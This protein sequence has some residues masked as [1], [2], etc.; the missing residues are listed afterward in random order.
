MTERRVALFIVSLSS[1]TIWSILREL[2]LID[3]KTK[4][5]LTI[6]SIIPFVFYTISLLNNY[7]FESKYFNFILPV[8]FLYELI[9][10]I[11]GWSFSYDDIKSYLETSYVFWPF[12]IPFFVFFDKKISTIFLLLK[13]IYFVGLGFLVISILSPF[14]LLTFNTA[15]TLIGL[16]VGCGFLLLN[17]NYLNNRKV[18][19]TFII[20]LITLLS[21]TYLA[22]RNGLLT[23][24]GFLFFAFFL[25]EFNRPRSLL[26]RLFPII[27]IGTI[28]L[29]FY[30]ESLTTTL[31]GRLVARFFEDTRSVLFQMY[32][33]DMVDNMVLGKGMNSIY[34]APMPEMAI[35][36]IIID[37]VEY[38]NIVEN[39]Y[40]Q[41][42]LTG[43]FIHI[44]LFLLVLLPAAFLGIFKS[45]NQ[46]TKACGVLIFLWLIDMFVYGLPRLS[47][48]YILI[49]I[50]VGICY[51]STIRNLT[52]EKINSEI[53]ET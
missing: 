24:S 27:I 15:E 9:L 29:F 14:L 45:S 35:D 32:Y 44:F 8:F 25:N 42:L 41:L 5:I 28:F 26:F 7:Q 21:L 16:A 50:C 33:I 49:W 17:A 10:V 3:G 13:W 6:F 12:V 38:R 1:L 19:F 2:D 31:G 23:L 40:L 37:P 4:T 30:S 22:R 39:G 43:G 34:Y 51:T 47:I 53:L 36:G 46:F 11:R 52:N 18:I 20:I 48:H